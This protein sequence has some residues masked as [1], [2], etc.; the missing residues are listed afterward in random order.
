MIYYICGKSGSG[1]S[2]ITDKIKDRAK[3]LE[4]L[5]C[6]TTRPQRPKEAT[7]RYKFVNYTQFLDTLDI[8]AKYV[9]DTFKPDGT[10]DTW[11]YYIRACDIDKSKDYIIEGTPLLAYQLLSNGYDVC[12]I[13]LDVSSHELLK[14][15]L[16]RELSSGNENYVE[17][18]RRFINDFNEFK[19]VKDRA[20][21]VITSDDIL[22]EKLDEILNIIVS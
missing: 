11:F 22:K 9:V 18:C 4:Y 14:R 10:E 17:M 21:Y 19:V 7:H 8:V 3:G 20:D 15:S 5:P 16:G 13:Y 2:T 1:K 6:Y 12:M